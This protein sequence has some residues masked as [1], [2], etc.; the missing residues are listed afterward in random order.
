MIFVV[1]N[2]FVAVRV[3]FRLLKDFGRLW[4]GLMSIG[5]FVI[6]SLLVII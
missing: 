5:M 6:V 2:C 3:D 1:C 4:I